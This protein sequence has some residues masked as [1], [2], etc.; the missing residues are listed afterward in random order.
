MST[1]ASGLSFS[2]V[3]ETLRFRL[4]MRTLAVLLPYK[5]ALLLN[6]LGE[7]LCAPGKTGPA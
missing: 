4:C 2:L 5:G 1:L 3:H 6:A 7:H